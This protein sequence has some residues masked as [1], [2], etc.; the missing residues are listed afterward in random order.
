[1]GNK[2]IVLEM[3]M[4]EKEMKLFGGGGGGRNAREGR[5]R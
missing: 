3:K 4:V 1:M 5:V 2:M